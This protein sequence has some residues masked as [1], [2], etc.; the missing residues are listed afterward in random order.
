MLARVPRRWLRCDDEQMDVAVPIGRRGGRIPAAVAWAAAGLVLALAGYA[1][2]GSP[3]DPFVLSAAATGAFSAVFAALLLTRSA[4]HPIGWLFFVIG[5]TRGVAA[6]AQVW[7]VDALV[8]HPGRPGGGL[9]SWLQLWTPS[10][11]LAL[12][13]AV[14]I[15]FPDGRLPGRRWRVVPALVA[16]SLALLA[17]VVPAGA[18]R[19]RGPALLPDAPVPAGRLAHVLDALNDTG[20]LLAGVSAAIALAGALVRFRRAHG[21]VRQQIKW[22][23]YGAGC[24]FALNIAAHLTGVGWLVPV[25]VAATFTGLG[26]G[27]FRFRLYDVDQVIR[28]TLLYG[29]VTVVLSAA[30]AALDVTAA[31]VTG[32]D[33]AATAALSAFLVA[34]LLRPVR[35]RAQD[36]VDRFYDRGAYDGARLMRRLG[37]RVG[38]DSVGPDQVRDALRRVLRDPGLD[39][40]YAVPAPPGQRGELVTGD[41]AP[42]GPGGPADGR[43]STPVRRGGDD[44]AYLVHGPV[45]PGLLSAVVPAAA[46]ALEH[47]RLQA[48]LSVQLAALRASRGRIVAAGDAER[49]RIERDLH[50]GAQQRL[51]GLAVHIQSARRQRG[52]AGD[53]GRLLDFTVDQLQASL[54][55]IRALVHG[56]L[57]PV[58][59]SGGLPAALAELRDVAV[60]C[61]LNRRPDPGIEATAWFVV[62]EGVANARKHAAGAEVSVR[63]TRQAAVIRVEV[64]DGG[65]GGARAGGAGLRNLADRVEAHGGTLRLDSPPGGG[66]VLTADLPCG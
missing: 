43:T 13:P 24:A 19:Y 58:L 38:R 41:G 16:V 22:F 2:A 11:G 4:R 46:T 52:H 9:A 5:L 28:R 40:L 31:V 51:V 59:V 54:D 17:V 35:T 44:I 18:W 65:P 47:A 42:A 39:V 12:A 45:D 63:V 26:L 3:G 56:I 61:D 64:R 1:L 53:T 36:V 29:L 60:R 8:N 27:I 6:A 15:L 33:S 23:G 25:G 57:P 48:E 10:A 66:T 50:D 21:D 34:L 30:F 20:L 37:Q 32:Q 7:S 14:I 49:R 55:D 62:C